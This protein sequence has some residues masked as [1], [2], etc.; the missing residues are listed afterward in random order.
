MKIS[1]RES[2]IFAED[3]QAMKAWYQDV[4]GFKVTLLAEE[5]YHY[6]NLENDEG[7]RIGIAD[8][9][10]M[11]ITPQDRSNNTVVLQFEVSDVK[12]FFAYL[13]E[14]GGSVTFGPSFDEKGGFWFGGFHDLEG[15]PFWVVDEN[16]P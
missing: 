12:I 9:K 15:N 2:V 11:G 6:V 14:K 10:E 1:P 7:V 16:C 8:A 5:D 3:F 4:L 13:Q